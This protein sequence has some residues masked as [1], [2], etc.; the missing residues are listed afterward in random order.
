MSFYINLPSNSSMKTY[1]DN[2]QASFTTLLK[3]P[4]QVPPGTKVALVVFECN[5]QIETNVGIL[6]IR[7][8]KHNSNEFEDDIEEEEKPVTY[9]YAIRSTF[10]STC[11]FF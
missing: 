11:R 7:Q 1:P 6:K 8:L 5:K 9:D 10:S 3:V 4:I 2:T